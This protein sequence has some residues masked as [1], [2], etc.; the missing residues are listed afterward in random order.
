[1]KIIKTLLQVLNKEEI[2]KLIAQNKFKEV[3]RKVS[4]LTYFQPSWT[5]NLTEVFYA[6]GINPLAYMDEIPENFLHSSTIKGVSIPNY[7]K[8]IGY[9][10]FSGCRN[11]TNIE[12]PDSVTTIID[13]AFSNCRNLKTIAIPDSV[14]SIGKGV[15]VNCTHLTSIKISNSIVRI[16]KDMFFNCYNLKAIAIPDSVTSVGDNAFYN[17]K[18]LTSIIIPYSTTDIGDNAFYN[19]E[20]L[21]IT[22]YSEKVKELIINSGFDENRI[23]V[24]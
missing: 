16:S 15:F 7:I 24:V 17:C 13:G 9:L 3:Y 19:C 8:T 11:L 18:S 6:A 5:H 4:R 21:T 20:Q 10:A 12:I 23:K 22:C 14:T 1:M 2:K